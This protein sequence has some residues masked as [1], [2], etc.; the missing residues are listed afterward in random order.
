MQLVTA[1][2]STGRIFVGVLIADQVV[3]TGYVDMIAFIEDGD[4]A[5]D[6]ARAALEQGHAL[7]GTTVLAP[8]P[9][10]GKMLFLGQSFREFRAGLSDDV[11]PFV[12][13]R[14]PSSIIGPGQAIVM[15]EPDITVLYE[16]ELLI[17]IGTQAKA[18]TAADAASHVFGYSQV[19]DLTWTDWLHRTDGGPQQLALC[20]N[21]D[22]FCPMGPF[23]VTADAFDPSAVDFGVRINGE[24][25][26]S[27][28]TTGLVWSVG[29]IIEFLSRTMTLWPG[30][31]IATGTPAAGPIVVGDEVVIHFDGLGELRNPVIAGY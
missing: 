11:D 22:T 7:A 4:R 6:R 16:A 30:D 25:V 3:D 23:I 17:V 1:Q 29:R 10:P 19:N 5:L 20:K 15:P 14:V 26:M 28:S 21:A 31:V 27:S 9:R 8:L 12:Y 18:V 24:Q 13:S 2:D